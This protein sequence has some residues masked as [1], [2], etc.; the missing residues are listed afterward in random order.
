M[1]RDLSP[2]DLGEIAVLS[3]NPQLGPEDRCAGSTR[4]V[5]P[6]EWADCRPLNGRPEVESSDPRKISRDRRYKLS[7]SEVRTL[8]ELGRFRVVAA[9]DLV[10]Y[11]YGGRTDE[12]SAELRDLVRKHLVRRGSFEGLEAAPRDLLTLTERGHQVVRTLVSE[13][14]AIHYGFVRA[15]EANHDADL[16]LL[17][18]KEA[19]RIEKEGGRTLRVIL[20]YELARKVNRDIAHFGT[21]S[22]PE[23]ARRHGLRVIGG[24]IPVPD[25]RIEY[26]TSERERAGVNLELV[27]EHYRGAS[28]AEKVRAGFSLYA[29]HHGAA[30]LRRLLNHH[31]LHA[32]IH[33]L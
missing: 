3:E 10:L 29:P 6:D 7:D 16:Y 14:Q 13:D 33:S 8:A 12:A 22:R 27:T 21:E 5:S 20:D 23:I 18:Q 11:V 25:L 17:Y 1:S 15:R 32:E 9:D 31:A 24:K 19:A 4:A 30:Y 2:Q 28:V 26:E